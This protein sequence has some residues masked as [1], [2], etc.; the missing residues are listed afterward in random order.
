MRRNWR[1]NAGELWR[2]GLQL[3]GG[4][5]RSTAFHCPRLVW[6]FSQSVQPDSG[7]DARWRAHRDRAL[8][9]ALV[10]RIRCFALV[11]MEISELHYLVDRAVIAAADLF[12]FP[13]TNRGRTALF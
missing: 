8:A 2:F 12:A 5:L 9:L 7:R 1:S 13:Q 10:A 6:V 4:S 3:P 11:R